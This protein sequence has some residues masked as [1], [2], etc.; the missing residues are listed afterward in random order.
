MGHLE[1]FASLNG[2]RF[3]GLPANEKRIELERVAWTIPPKV[4]LPDGD[5]VVP[6]QAGEAVAWRLVARG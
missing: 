5:S 1:A 2:P 4:D 3:Y 6:F